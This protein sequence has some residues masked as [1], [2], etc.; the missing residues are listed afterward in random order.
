[1]VKKHVLIFDLD[2]TLINSKK[3]HAEAYNLAFEKNRLER[4]PVDKVI[5]LFGI[6]VEDVIKKLYPDISSRRLPDCAKDQKEIVILQ[7]LF[8][9]IIIG[10]LMY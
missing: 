7:T 8:G 6:P 3:A 1:M 5:S 10:I 4:L 2:G 9:F